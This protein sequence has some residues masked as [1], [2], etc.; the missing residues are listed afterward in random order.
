MMRTAGRGW[1]MSLVM[2]L[3]IAPIPSPSS[4]AEGGPQAQA[5]SG[6]LARAATTTPGGAALVALSSTLLGL[7][8][9]ALD[10][11][12][13]GPWVPAGD[14]HALPLNLTPPLAVAAQTRS[15]AYEDGCHAFPKIRRAKGCS[16]GDPDAD[17]TVLILGDSHGAMWLPAFE[18][19]AAR[20]GWRIHLLTKSACPP[21]RIR[22]LFRRRVYSACEEWRR[23]A[24]QVAQRLK[25]D[26][27]VVTST[28]GYAID[29]IRT[30]YSRPYLAA[31]REGWAD[32]LR[33]LGRTEVR[34]WCSTTAPS[35]R[36]TRSPA[37]PGMLRTCAHVPHPGMRRCARMW[38]ERLDD[39]PGMRTRR[40]STHRC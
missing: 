4:A 16:Y 2:V 25:P 18:A 15:R 34:S 6:P 10:T 20:R 23:S 17:F 27:A 35:G 40:S 33:T 32:T 5:A 13:D 26:L 29:G 21:A 1:L 36:R 9:H 38:H 24:F 7:L 3:A 12:D 30:R 8:A 22:V 11:V 28:V 14:P 31:W 39:P 37:Y 19:I